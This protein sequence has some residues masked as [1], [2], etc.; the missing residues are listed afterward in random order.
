MN[1][2]HDFKPFPLPFV[3]RCDNKNECKMWVNSDIFGDPCPGT[4]K[5]VEVHFACKPR[6]IVAT[7]TKR[8][9]PPWFLQG[10]AD[11]L[12][13]NPKKSSNG[14]NQNPTSSSSSTTLT[15]SNQMDSSQENGAIFSIAGPDATQY[16]ERKPILVTSDSSLTTTVSTTPVRI[17]I[18]TPR[19]TSTTTASTST[20]TTS[21]EATMTTTSTFS[22]STLSTTSILPELTD[23]D[24]TGITDDINEYEVEQKG[25]IL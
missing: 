17:P 7:T 16:T 2:L 8:P 12:W 10:G 1:F 20:S 11:N 15:T 4:H 5:Y 18:T 19:P 3:S 23:Q 22:S 24:W 14:Q 6:I 21:S 13:N 25:K 9:W